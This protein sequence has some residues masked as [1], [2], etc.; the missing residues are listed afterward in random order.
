MP[1]V[2]IPDFT[3][4][5]KPA[6]ADV[7]T[8]E[9]RIVA[10]VGGVH[11]GT[12]YPGALDANNV[13]A[14]A[15]FRLRQQAEWRSRIC[16]GSGRHEAAAPPSGAV[17]PSVAGPHC[18]VASEVDIDCDVVTFWHTNATALK[19]KVVVSKNGL[20]LTELEFP[21]PDGVAQGVLQEF[22]FPFSLLAGDVIDFLWLDGTN[23]LV[24]TAGAAPS[25]YARCFATVW[26]VTPHVA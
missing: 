16:L 4:T 7:R 11:E 2:V 5:A 3:V 15:A 22:R 12:R 14:T 23:C 18:I 21:A 19:G 17:P 6:V 24:T 8:A 10:V 13:A 25:A 1:L 20:A 9:Q 26:G